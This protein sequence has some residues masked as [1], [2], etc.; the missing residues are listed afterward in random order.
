MVSL[1]YVYFIIIKKE[2]KNH[3]LISGSAPGWLG[4]C[5]RPP[6]LDTQAPFPVGARDGH[7]EGLA[8]SVHSSSARPCTEPAQPQGL[9]DAALRPKTWTADLLAPCL[10]L[11][12]GVHRARLC[13]AAM[14]GAGGRELC[15]ERGLAPALGGQGEHIERNRRDVAGPGAAV[16]LMS[17]NRPGRNRHPHFTTESGQAPCRPATV[18]PAHLSSISPCVPV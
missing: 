3:R 8:P 11:G 12:P 17:P 18:A 10:G 4:P 9:R 1:Y 7:L 13:P 6:I 14:V 2:K 16:P 15:G 5:P